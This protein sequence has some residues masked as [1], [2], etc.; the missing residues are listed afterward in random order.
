MVQNKWTKQPGSIADLKEEEK[1][2]FRIFD[3]FIGMNA[4]VSW[5]AT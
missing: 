2:N 5:K 1:V 3:K 4:Q